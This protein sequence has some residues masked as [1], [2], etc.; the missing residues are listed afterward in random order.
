VLRRSH[1]RNRPPTITVSGSRGCRRSR[2]QALLSGFLA[3]LLVGLGPPPASFAATPFTARITNSTN[4][5]GSATYFTCTNAAIGDRA[6]FAYPLSDTGTTAADISGNGRAG[7]YQG[8]TTRTAAKACARDTGGSARLNGTNAYISTPAL[9]ANPAVFT[10]EVWFNTTTTTGGKLIGFGNAQTG[11]SNTYD[12]HVYLTNSGQVVF[13]V[14]PNAVRTVISPRSYNDGAWHHAVA[15]LSTAGMALYVDG[16][17]A[18]SDP[19]VTTAQAYAGFWRIGFDN[20]NGWTSQ[21]SSSYFAGS[22]AYAA[23]YTTAL[24]A[25]QVKSHYIAGR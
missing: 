25:T 15:T 9:V 24:T 5:V 12:R 22:L 17:L 19:A 11:T 10:V 14:Y 21:P 1:H 16:A 7:T 6:F 23:V 18:A 3:L 2:R 20:L 13:G 4:T 8:T